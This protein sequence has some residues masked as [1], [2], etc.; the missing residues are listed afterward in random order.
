M[1]PPAQRT[2][3]DECNWDVHAWETEDLQ[4]T[5]GELELPVVQPARARVDGAIEWRRLVDQGDE[6][7]GAERGE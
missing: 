3:R 1:G 2:R 4:R 6:R 7:E 5:L